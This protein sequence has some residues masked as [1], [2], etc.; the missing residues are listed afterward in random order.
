LP[1]DISLSSICDT[2]EFT[3]ILLLAIDLF[4]ALIA[5]IYDVFILINFAHVLFIYTFAYNKIDREEKKKENRQLLGRTIKLPKRRSIIILFV[6]CFSCLHF[7]KKLVLLIERFINPR[8]RTGVHVLGT[9][10]D[11][12]STGDPWD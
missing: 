3:Q 7:F 5:T 10:L 11:S 9:E 1:N 8:I 4:E 6:W 2:C 12:L